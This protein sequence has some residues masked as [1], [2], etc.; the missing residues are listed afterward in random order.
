MWNAKILVLKHVAS[1]HRIIFSLHSTFFQNNSV[2]DCT[3]NTQT[4]RPSVVTLTFHFDDSRAAANSLR[5]AKEKN[6]WI[7]FRQAALDQL[8]LGDATRPQLTQ[9]RSNRGGGQNFPGGI[10]GAAGGLNLA[11]GRK[12]PFRILAHVQRC[13]GAAPALS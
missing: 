11:G 12:G 3:P 8:F 9:W 5:V 13:N 1:L 10:L 7:T 6:A 2:V 4:L